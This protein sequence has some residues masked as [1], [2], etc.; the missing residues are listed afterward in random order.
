M[1]PWKLDI[2]T[3]REQLGL[4][5]KALASA[6]G[7]QRNTVARWERGELRISETMM[8]RLEGVA[9]ACRSSTVRRSSAIVLDDH[10]RAILNA[11]NG[12][13]DPEAFEACA[14][15][16]LRSEWPKLVPVRGGGDDGFDG[17]VADPTG[18][19]FPL[20]T[21]TGVKLVDNFARSLNRAKSRD[22]PITSALFATPR[23][24]TPHSRKRLF[25]AARDRGVTLSQIYDQDWFAQTLYREPNW[26]KRLLGLTGRPA[27]LS[28]FP[29]TRRPVLGDAVL[30]REREMAWLREQKGD[31]LLVGEPG[32]GKTF[33]LRTLA[34][35]GHARFLVDH[36]RTQ[37][38]NDL[39]SLCPAAVIVDDAH[40]DPTQIEK[41][42]QIRS[43]ARALFRIIATSWPGDAEA[44]RSALKV[45]STREMKLDRIDEDTMVEIIKSL[46]VHRPDVQGQDLLLNVIRKQASGRPGLAAT[47]VHLHRSGNTRD[48]V[49]GE[50]LV[51]E[52]SRSIGQIMDGDAV[53]LLA[54]FAL[55]G[56]AGAKQVAVSNHLGKP[57][58]DLSSDLARLGAAGV[59]RERSDKAISV[60]PEAMRWPIVKQIFF[61]GPGALDVEPF[62]KIVETRKDALR[63]LIG[64][65]WLC[66]RIP[67]LERWLEEANLPDLWLDYSLLG[68]TEA[69]YVFQ[70]HPESIGAAYLQRYPFI[71]DLLGRRP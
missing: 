16:L 53:R 42:D 45:G 29:V 19:P 35:A 56:D 43:E 33:L 47:L 8:D 30:G 26:C 38:A 58:L 25:D 13:L 32:S 17:A 12:K 34:L 18:E 6:V 40:V 66:A 24:I 2:K 51:A 41:L 28:L 48:V 39:R 71:R 52:L 31:C 23:R 63:T 69:L 37:I 60:E 10:H 54:P 68:H 11:L 22:W 3:L 62:L 7:V 50:S 27:A 44:V 64:A 65:R 9:N 59:V 20:I 55:G 70:R 4:T 46:G 15:D 21:T 14:A 61:D 57:L 49:S 36:D 5:Q 67:D 1:Y